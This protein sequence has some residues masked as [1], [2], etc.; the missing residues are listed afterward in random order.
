M[1]TIVGI[2]IPDSELA[3]DAR[4][5]ALELSPD[6]LLAHVDRTYVFGALAAARAG[7]AV[8]EEIAYVA[9]ILHDLGLTDRHGGERRF[10]VDGAE[11]ARA[12]A[13]SNGM[14][15]D[16][17]QRVWD[18]I[19]LH[20]SPGIAEHRSPECALVHWG[21]GIDVLGFGAD[22]LTP[23]VIAEVHRAFPRD[24]FADGMAD[25]LEA[26]ARRSPAAY[27]LTWLAETASRCCGTSMPTFD[28][29]LRRDPYA[30]VAACSEP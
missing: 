4:E 25:L 5:V 20:A 3:R 29:F 21:A 7:L 30:T 6:F 22:Q 1:N 18:A 2:R 28:S 27:A 23:A 17:A 8:D 24:G 11:A 16:E 26:A 19:A 9:A 10:E 12:W 15:A 14:S 13:L